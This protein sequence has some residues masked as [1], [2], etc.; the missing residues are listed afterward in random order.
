MKHTPGPW[1]V[2]WLESYNG[3]TGEPEAFVYRLPAGNEEETAHNRIC[4]RGSKTLMDCDADAR[5]I[6]AAPELLN[7]L[8]AFIAYDRNGD[9][10]T[11]NAEERYDAITAQAEAV[12]RKARGG[13]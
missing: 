6:A 3:A 13:Q 9:A 11:A 12:I 7:A 10:F 4:V 5:L 2:G 1:R 8:E